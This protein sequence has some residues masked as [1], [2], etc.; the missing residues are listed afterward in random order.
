MQDTKTTKA[1]ER[2]QHTPGP[3]LA[4]NK[5]FNSVAPLPYVSAGDTAKVLCF[6]NLSGAYNGNAGIPQAQADA[7][8]IASAPE[9]LEA[10]WGCLE[11]E[12]VSSQAVGTDKAR[13]YAHEKARRAIAKAEGRAE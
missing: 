4:R 7:R 2:T 6:M 10:L 11:A 13:H 1:G 5:H 3:W 12:T 8:L 9:L